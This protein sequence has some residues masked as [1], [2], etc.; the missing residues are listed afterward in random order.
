MPLDSF[1]LDPMLAPF[2]NM[3][4]DCKSRNITGEDFDIIC[5]CYARMEE[6][7]QSTDDMNVFSSTMM[8]EN[9]YGKFSD[10][11]SRALNAQAQQASS[12]GENSGGGYDDGALLKQSINFLK[13]SIKRHEDNYKETLRMASSE[14][15][16]AQNQKALEFTTRSQK[17]TIGN[18]GGADA[19]IKQTEKSTTEQKKSTPNMFDNTVEV[20]MTNNPEPLI[21]GIQK[22]I[23]L[24]EQPGMTYPKFLR[25]QIETGLDKAMEGTG[26]MREGL[27]Y[28][29]EFIVASPGNPYNIEKAKKKIEAFD[30]LAEGN[31]FKIPD[32][33]ELNHLHD[34]IDREFEP[35]I[36][37][38]EG[39]KRIWEK[40]IWDL[41]DWSLSYCSFAPKIKPWLDAEDPVEA[42]IFTQNTINGIFPEREKMLN[43][44]FGMSFMDIFKH[45]TFAFDVEQSY[46]WI[47][48]ELMEFLIEE[49]YPHCKALTHLPKEIIEKRGQFNAYMRNPGD[50]EM[51]PDLHIPSERMR[52][53]YNKK[54]G[55]GRYESKYSVAEK[56]PNCYAKPWD[57][58]TFKYG[59]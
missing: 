1:I 33:R 4:E 15:N 54:F 3:V 10:H 20:E 5:K 21:K 45:P 8:Q 37:K 38:W 40:M 36:K 48:Q 41:S 19:F 28:S 16:E 22:V 18:S 53:F 56:N 17:D 35:Q 55:E 34:D 52:T 26:V 12:S 7:G 14:Y 46:M 57:L 6:L 44:Y 27:I 49:V 39:I 51:N 24:G 59:K 42:T 23:D 2:K 25:L 43:K 32:L 31:R 47:S 29:H 11:Y 9:L 30:K 13:D 50:R 58:S